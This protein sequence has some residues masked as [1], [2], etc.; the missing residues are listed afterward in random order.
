VTVIPDL[1]HTDY[2]KMPALSVSGMKQLLP[3]SCP[4]LFKHYRENRRP[5]KHAYDIGHVAHGLILGDGPEVVIVDAGD[6]RTKYAREL[7]ENA[8]AE[9]KVPVL[10]SEYEQCAAMAASVRSNPTAADLLA[11]GKPEQTLTWTDSTGVPMRARV[12]W[13]PNARPGRRFTA[14]DLKTTGGSAHPTEFARAAA[15]FNYCMQARHYL[16]GIKAC[17]LD[18]D[19]A[20]VLVVVETS[21]PYLVSLV[22]FT[23]EDL[24]IGAEKI[25]AA[26][27]I[28]RGCIESGSWPGYGEEIAT[29]EMPAWYRMDHERDVI[30]EMEIG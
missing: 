6:W 20:F 18:D 3:P 4:A 5:E 16:D 14:V 21:A 24:Q 11:D 17:G 8:Y 9:G 15:K 23:D 29:I 10:L 12:D 22:Q 30:E 26:V 25:A 27:Q 13:L 1:P 28:Y 7:R 19:P 2:L